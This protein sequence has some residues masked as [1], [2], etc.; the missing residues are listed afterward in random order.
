MNTQLLL[1]IAD[2]IETR[3]DLYDQRTGAPH[4]G[5]ADTADCPLCVAGNAIRLSEASIDGPAGTDPTG[6]G[7]ARTHC[8]D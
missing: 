3:P 8:S 7:P 5:T 2:E 4:Y 6:C 1:R